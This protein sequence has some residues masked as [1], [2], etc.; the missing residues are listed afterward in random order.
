M[1]KPVNDGNREPEVEN[2]ERGCPV[3]LGRH[4][5][6]V[7]WVILMVVVAGHGIYQCT[8][9]VSE[10][11]EA[12]SAGYLV[13]AERMAAGLPLAVEE[14]D[15]LVCHEHFWVENG[16]GKTVPKYPPGQPLLMAAA[17][18]LSGRTL[19][20][21]LN[22]LFGTLALLGAYLLFRLWTSATASLLATFALAS[23][24]TYL[25]YT[26]YPLS[27]SADV[28]L[29]T[30]GMFFLWKW[31]RAPHAGWGL[32]AG[33]FLGYSQFVR[34][35]NAL[36]VLS[37]LAAVAFA[38]V[39]RKG[40]GVKW[41]HLLALPAA[42]AIF[43]ILHLAY[44]ASVF[45]HPLTTG[46]A[47]SGEQS[48][49]SFP[50][51]KRNASYA[52]SI[53]SSL[54]L[55]IYFGIGLVGILTDKDRRDVVLKLLWVVPIFLLYA[56]YYWAPR[57]NQGGYARFFLGLFPVVVGSA[58]ALLDRVWSSDWRRYA[59]PAG[60]CAIVFLIRLPE[61][62][63][64]MNQNGAMRAQVRRKA[65]AA[66]ETHLTRG[67]II[68]ST[69]PVLWHVGRGNGFRIYDLAAFGDEYLRDA[70][71]PHTDGA[72]RWQKKR[73]NRF[74]AF[75]NRNAD[76][77]EQLLRERVRSFL[78]DGRQVV[79]LIPSGLIGECE[80]LLGTRFKLVLKVDWEASARRRW[81]LHAVEMSSFG[82]PEDVGL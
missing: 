36:L 2:N 66:A 37:V 79:F 69:Y 59:L 9:F 72:V 75:Y 3:P 1:S 41:L 31:V 70:F 27:H 60:L 49:F 40:R 65:V 53:L 63:R 61:A 81:G 77:L 43:P 46:Y 7:P 78:A 56:A 10:C 62:I 4:G 39:E 32:G 34:P 57:L 24:P 82:A 26:S 42:Y 76:R 67:S 23:N 8:K 47:L 48:G 45:G 73:R 58:F 55:S 71:Y 12:D 52:L 80:E 64:G 74:V 30:W 16:Q 11:A 38:L 22:P 35:A 19:A 14:Q 15:P 68:F 29:I 20:F 54:G 5:Q 44:N 25:F 13:L 21:A 50:F 33:L 18:W 6:V 17:I 51:L 28:F